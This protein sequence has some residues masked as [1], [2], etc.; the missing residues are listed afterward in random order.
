MTKIVYLNDEHAQV[1]KRFAKNA[2][3][4]GSEE[5]LMWK[6]Y[7]M[8]FPKAIMVVKEIKK[9]HDKKTNRNMTYENMKIYISEHANK[10]VML[11][12][13]ARQLKISK[14]KKNPY[15]YVLSWFD[16][17]YP[18]ARE[19]L[20]EDKEDKTEAKKEAVAVEEQCQEESVGNAVALPA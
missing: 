19:Y 20:K 17:F 7:R 3:V 5:Y 13:F 16:K 1:S 6:E 4:F 10:D 12:E 9:N 14:I 2:K 15:R 8:D 11:N 18:S